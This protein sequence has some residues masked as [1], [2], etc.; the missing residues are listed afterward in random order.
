MIGPVGEIGRT[1]THLWIPV[2]GTSLMSA[3]LTCKE[4]VKDHLLDDPAVLVN[5][6]QEV[7]PPGGRTLW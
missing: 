2:D 1:D 4:G 5:N 3:T 7:I 6:H